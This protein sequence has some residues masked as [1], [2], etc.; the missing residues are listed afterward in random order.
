MLNLC[1]Y[2]NLFPDFQQRFFLSRRLTAKHSKTLS[3]PQVRGKKAR[4]RAKST[5]YSTA[6]KRID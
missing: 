5:V 4:Q 1:Q 6:A 2:Y 3:D